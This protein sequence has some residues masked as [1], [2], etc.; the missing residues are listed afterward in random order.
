ML[1]AVLRSPQVEQADYRF[2]LKLPKDLWLMYLAK[3][4]ADIDYP[5]FKNTVPLKDRA[6]HEA[7]M[8]CWAALR[9]WQDE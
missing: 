6:R 8:E 9:R 7:Y 1:C 4:G 2:R 3:K 5:N